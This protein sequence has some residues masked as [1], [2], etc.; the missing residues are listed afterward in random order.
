[1]W[2]FPVVTL[3]ELFANDIVYLSSKE[4]MAIVTTPMHVH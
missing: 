3:Q 2:I 4:K 1:M